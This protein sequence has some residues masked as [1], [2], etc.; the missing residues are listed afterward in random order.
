MGETYD[1]AVVGTG[2]IGLAVTAELLARGMTVAVIGPDSGDCAGQATR[3]AGAM[4]SAFAEI[5]PRHNTQRT[6]VE[7]A[8]RLAAH[9]MYPT[10]LER[11]ANDGGAPLRVEPGTWV[12]AP[13]GRGKHLEPIAAAARAA[14]H[15]AEVHDPAQIPGLNPPP[16]SAGALWLPTEGRIDSAALMDALTRSVRIHPH[17]TWRD[18]LARSVAAGRVGCVDDTEVHAQQVVIA[19]G[20]A[21]PGLLPHSGRALGVPPILAGRGVSAVLHAP[22]MPG[23][24]HVV[25]TP[26]A[27]FAC[28]MHVVP[29]AGQTLYVGATNR[30]TITPDSDRPATLGE[31]AVLAG[32]AS[33]LLDPRLGAAGVLTIRTGLRPYTLD[34]LPLLGR[35]REPTLL[36][37]TAT[38]RCGILLAPRAATLIADEITTPGT[39][40]Q[41][42]YR[43]LRPMPT[44]EINSVLD[45][46]A[47][48]L[49]E[50]LLQGGGQLPSGAAGEFTAFTALALRALLDEQSKAGTALRHLWQAAPVAEALP[51]LYAL[52]R[53]LEAIP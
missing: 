35:T 32:E 43:T 18:A 51:S 21:I 36:L 30:L 16:T 33:A 15:P 47:A 41:H 25:R 39:L 4:L 26:N 46:G 29:G 10:W 48:D 50:H 3:A 23:V 40:D 24:Q 11:I 53:R 19:A 5:E 12:L 28:G 22:A 31:L 27:A 44:P 7:T 2:V 6:A 17:C 45:E 38:Y 8:E 13:A 42:P 34:H 9:A 52:A 49:L 14:G 20:A 1:V 37:A